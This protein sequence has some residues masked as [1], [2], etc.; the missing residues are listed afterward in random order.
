MADTDFIHPG[1]IVRQLCLE[2][3]NLSVTEAATVLG[4]SRQA[5]TNLLSGKAGISPEM[6]L[7]LDKAF[8]GGAETWLQRQLVHDLARAR[9]RFDDLAVM[10]MAQ[11]R[12]RSLF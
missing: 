7:R 1:A 3:F 8:G 9:E 10:S 4:V 5:L 12:Q 6:A 11:Q 2:R